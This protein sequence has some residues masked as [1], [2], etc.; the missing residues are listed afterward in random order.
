MLEDFEERIVQILSG[1]KY[2]IQDI[3][4]KGSISFN[5]VS[6]EEDNQ[7]KHKFLYDN[8]KSLRELEKNGQI[9][10]LDNT[11]Y[12]L[13][14][15]EDGDKLNLE[16]IEDGTYQ[17]IS[18]YISIQKVLKDDVRYCVIVERPVNARQ[19]G[20][21]ILAGPYRN[22]EE[23]REMVDYFCPEKDIYG[24]ERKPYVIATYKDDKWLKYHYKK[25]QNCN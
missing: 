5:L 24:E 19:S 23:A 9:E 7:T 12:Y 17:T 6:Y 15:K 20:Q 13:C 14:V 3:Y 22:L 25:V 2:I 11:I 1:T 21:F 18:S 16:I 8:D 10:I 4:D